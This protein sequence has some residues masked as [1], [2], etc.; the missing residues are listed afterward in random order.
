LPDVT[1]VLGPE[2]PETLRAR[3]SHARWTGQA[4]EV[5]QARDLFAALLPGVTR[6]LGPD[7]PD[8][9]RTRDNLVRWNRL[10]TDSGL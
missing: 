5:G 4:G 2:R 6:V 3:A 9:Y 7:H 10:A 8:T 1:R